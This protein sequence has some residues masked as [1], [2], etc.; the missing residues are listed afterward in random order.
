M[1]GR[2]TAVA[3]PVPVL[4][5]SRGR[6][7]AGDTRRACGADHLR[8]SRP[9]RPGPRSSDTAGGLWP[10]PK[11]RLAREGRPPWLT[12]SRRCVTFARCV[13]TRGEWGCAGGGKRRRCGRPVCP[14][15]RRRLP[16]ALAAGRPHFSWVAARAAAAAAERLACTWVCVAG[17][18]RPAQLRFRTSARGPLHR[19]LLTRAAARPQS[20]LATVY[21]HDEEKVRAQPAP[22]PGAWHV[23]P[24][25]GWP[26]QRRPRPARLVACP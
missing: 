6:Q 2:A 7:R 1:C 22:A 19:L 15:A 23:P 17:Q 3:S 18:A 25:P 8:L 26:C 9:R 24:E 4:S 14:P 12:V 10:S 21:C 5:A 16:R 13:A 20:A 11:T